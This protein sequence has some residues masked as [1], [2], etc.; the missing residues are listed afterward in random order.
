MIQNDK[1]TGFSNPSSSLEARTLYYVLFRGFFRGR[2]NVEKKVLVF[3]KP[4]PIFVFCKNHNYVMIYWGLQNWSHGKIKKM[5]VQLLLGKTLL[6]SGQLEHFLT[7]VGSELGSL[8]LSNSQC[9]GCCFNISTAHT[10]N[11]V[12]VISLF[13]KIKQKYVFGVTRCGQR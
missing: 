12:L 7:L 8:S 4:N 5:V 11:K 10:C 2:N 9:Q 6:L 1:V 13:L 3:F